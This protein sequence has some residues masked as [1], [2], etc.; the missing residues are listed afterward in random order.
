MS[1]SYPYVD[2]A[3]REGPMRRRRTAPPSPYNRRLREGPQRPR[4]KPPKAPPFNRRTREGPYRP[5]ADTAS[6][7]APTPTAAG[8]I[9]TPTPAF[10]GGT[11]SYDVGSDPAVA[12]IGALSER[13]RAEAQ[14]SAAA[15]KKQAAL[16]YGDPT[17]VEGIDEQTAKA[18]RE[19]PFSILRGMEHSYGLGV[20]DLEEGLN[21]GNLFYSGYR[22]QQLGEAGRTYQQGRY[23]AGN[24]FRST[25]TDIND[26]LAAALLQADMMDADAA[27]GS[28]GGYYDP[29]SEEQPDDGFG[30]APRGPNYLFGDV[31]KLLS[32]QSKRT[33]R[34]VRGAGVPAKKA[35]RFVVQPNRA[36]REGPPLVRAIKKAT[37]RPNPRPKRTAGGK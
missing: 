36:S 31:D 29:G 1:T 11:G 20:Q 28:D 8:S 30:L 23:D 10:S 19:N 21:K 4:M 3:S 24:R 33:G 25:I 9:Q 13:M 27:M 37:P 7:Y 14:A 15:K 16:E 2:R 35:N 22:G 12:R 17:G 6:E 34:G 32:G 5:G 18:A 26:A